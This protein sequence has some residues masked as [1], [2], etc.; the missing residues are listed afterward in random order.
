VVAVSL[1]TL[2]ALMVPYALAFAVTWTALLLVWI[3]T[4]FDLG[5]A[6]PLVYTP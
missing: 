4:G 3:A 1:G 5:P 6:G 2:V